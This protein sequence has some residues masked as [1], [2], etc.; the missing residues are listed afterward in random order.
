M[1]TALSSQPNLDD[2]KK[3][4]RELLHALQRRDAPALRRYYCIDRLDELAQPRLDD[5][6]YVIAREHGYS[7]WQKLTE[8]LPT[9]SNSR[10]C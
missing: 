7:S 1:C 9:T 8:H 4:A 3:E 6:Q 10:N 5:A 2:I